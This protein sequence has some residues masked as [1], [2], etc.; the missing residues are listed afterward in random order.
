MRLSLQD[1][2]TS[3]DTDLKTWRGISTYRGF[4]Q[5]P[6]HVL[7]IVPS[8]PS[9]WDFATCRVKPP[10]I[11]ATCPDE[12]WRPWGATNRALF[13]FCKNHLDVVQALQSWALP[14]RRKHNRLGLRPLRRNVPARRYCSTLLGQ[15][16]LRGRSGATTTAT[17]TGPRPPASPFGAGLDFA[18]RKIRRPSL[19]WTPSSWA[20]ASRSFTLDSV[21]ERPPCTRWLIAGSTSGLDFLLTPSCWSRPECRLFR[22][23]LKTFAPPSIATADSAMSPAAASRSSWYR[24]KSA[25]SLANPVKKHHGVSAP[26]QQGTPNRPRTSGRCSTSHGNSGTPVVTTTLATT[27]GGTTI[28]WKE[29]G[30]MVSSPCFSKM[31]APDSTYLTTL[32]LKSPCCIAKGTT[33]GVLHTG[34]SCTWPWKT[35]RGAALSDGATSNC[36][37]NGEGGTR[38]ATH[39]GTSLPCSSQPDPWRMENR[40]C[41]LFID[42]PLS[43]ETTVCRSTGW[44]RRMAAKGTVSGAGN[45]KASA[46]TSVIRDSSAMTL[47]KH[48]CSGRP[49]SIPVIALIGPKRC[50]PSTSG[51][52]LK[53]K[54][55]PYLQ[56]AH[57]APPPEDH[58]PASPWD[59]REPQHAPCPWANP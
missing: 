1:I 50:E 8:F 59:R 36:Q 57:A 56:C 41:T 29:P 55:R 45:S 23:P 44:R 6:H 38:S 46:Q 54:P 33:I 39:A 14:V 25:S 2:M 27:D 53:Q 31:Q 13:L 48:T 51:A 4:N 9:T 28:E 35:A 3:R 15:R 10:K 47:C 49:R 52:T 18:E 43:R 24:L 32:S 21:T 34:N 7:S 17:P 58:R 20:R 12:T 22:V 26:S 40:G 16:W 19:P 5:Q 37:V 42:S 11:A 30:I